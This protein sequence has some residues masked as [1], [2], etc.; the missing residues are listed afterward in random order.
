MM[1]RLARCLYKLRI[2]RCQ[3]RNLFPVESKVS[4]KNVEAEQHNFLLLMELPQE[5]L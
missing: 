1:A 5:R 2:G 4:E 3:K